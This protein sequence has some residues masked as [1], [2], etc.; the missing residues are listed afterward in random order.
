MY[1]VTI[2]PTAAKQLRKLP[3]NDGDRIRRGLRVLSVD[4]TTP[5]S[6]ADI[7]LLHGEVRWKY[8][9]RIGAFRIVY[10]VEGESVFVYEVFRRG[11]GRSE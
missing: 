7:H 3:T 11:R 9:L 1:H 8:R 5:R 10:S 4:P 6:G 2:S